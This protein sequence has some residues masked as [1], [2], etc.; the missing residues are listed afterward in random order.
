MVGEYSLGVDFGTTFTAAAV[1]HNGD[2]EGVMLTGG[3]LTAPSVLY[4][5]PDGDTLIGDDAERHGATEPTRVVRELKRR[6][7]DPTPLVIDGTPWPA[8][9][10]VARLLHWVLTRVAHERGGQ[11]TSVTLTHPAAWGGFRLELLEQAATHAGLP[12]VRLLSE[13]AAAAAFYASQRDLAIGTRV[14]VYDLGG[15]T[16]DAAVVRATSDGFVVEGVPQGLDFVGGLSFDDAVFAY[17]RESIAGVLEALDLND[18]TAMADV[19]E[20]RRRCT[21]AKEAL[22]TDTLA[23]IAVRLEAVRTDVRITRDEFENMIRPLVV[24]TMPVL[25]RVVESAGLTPDALDSVLLV[26]GSS[27][28]PLVG[29]LVAAEF[30][31]PVSTDA[32]PKLAVALGA[33]LTTTPRPQIASAATAAAMAATPTRSAPIVTPW[34]PSAAQRAPNRNAVLVGAAALVVLVVL[35]AAFLVT[36]SSSPNTAVAAGRDPTTTTSSTTTST[37]VASPSTTAAAAPPGV[38]QAAAGPNVAAVGGPATSSPAA[39]ESGVSSFPAQTSPTAPPD[40]QAP[41]PALN[42]RLTLS[43]NSGPA[44]TNVTANGSGYKPGEGIEVYMEGDLVVTGNADGAGSFS[45]HFTVPS[46][47]ADFPGES[48][49]VD[50]DGVDSVAT[51]SAVFNVT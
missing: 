49:T 40:T 19:L 33:A 6:L 27:R 9:L 14:A 41:E 11:P 18:A 15:G 39:F 26:G 2:C 36:R 4:V 51:A 48:V 47:W 21:Q 16:F 17:V 8:D 22:S 31:R 42:P 3:S 37:T 34:E 13:P 24:E 23:T 35:V 43:P 29:Q 46:F 32:N 25:C 28:I 38:T 45:L 5:G 44:G 10:L 7:G 1:A 20:L 50:A 30:G 12:N